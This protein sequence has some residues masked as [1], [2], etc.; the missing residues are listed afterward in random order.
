MS[1]SLTVGIIG[2]PGA[3][4]LDVVGPFD[5][6][7]TAA[8]FVTGNA[9]RYECLLLGNGLEAFDSESG[10][11][12]VPHTSLERAPP[13]DTLIIAGGRG[14]REPA[15]SA[16]IVAWLRTHA[17][18]CRRVAS[19]CT[20]IYGLAPTG[21]LDGRRVATHW[22]YA[23]DVA[24]QFPALKV[25]AD[26]IYV[27]DGDFWTSAG[28]TA[29]IDLSLALIEADHGAALALAVARE[30]VVYLKRDGGQAQ[31]SEPLRFQSA[32][33]DRLG[34]VVAWIE[35][36]LGADL[37]VEVLAGRAC[38]SPRHLTRQF[39]SAFG[40]APA[41]L[42]ETLRLDEARRRLA[43]SSGSI[44]RIAESIGFHN[45]DTFRRA[46]ERR[47]GLA[48]RIY[49]SRFRTPTGRHAEVRRIARSSRRSPSIPAQRGEGDDR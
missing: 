8:G 29:G 22:R 4:A 10:V 23:A 35:T 24:R 49:R 30:L 39:R 31:F 25:A 45:A 19:I 16:P 9:P 40:L 37:S 44:E 15:I 13:L 3:M 46:F 26:A 47:F 5:A 6:F 17:R 41:E 12:L 1:R 21:L 36:H 28:V 48:P 33:R 7:A 2:Y 11:R 42:V 20:G 32:N 34:D 43:A 18:R 38:V 14:L 27:Q